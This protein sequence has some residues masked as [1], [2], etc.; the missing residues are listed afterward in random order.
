MRALTSRMSRNR[1]AEGKADPAPSRLKYRIQ[2][3]MLTPGIRTGLRVGLPLGVILIAAGSYLA[4]ETRRDHLVALYNE[5]RASFETRPEFMVNV[6]A[7]DGAGESVATDIREVTSLDLPLSS[8]DLDLPAIRD[9][10]VGLDPVKTAAVRIRPGGILQVDV[11]ERE[12]AIV[13]RSRDGLA[14]LDETGAF[15]AELGQRSLHPELPLIAGR[16]A[17]K[18]AAEALRLFAAARPLGDRLRGIVRIGER[19][20]DVVLDRG[21]R[22]QLPVER[23]VAALERVIAV[24][25]VKDLLERDVAVVDLRLPARLTVRMNAPAVEDWWRIRQLNESS[26]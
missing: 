21:Q 25:E 15:V 18:R 10:I 12:P 1:A 26:Y 2:R 20:W 16:G 22:I 14:L 13:W 23:P 17:D 7:I 6:M 8:F 19:R 11:V 24:S 5:A 3:W 9:L 4:S